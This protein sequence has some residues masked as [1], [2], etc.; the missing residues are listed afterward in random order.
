[1]SCPLLIDYG[2]WV[3]GQLL[4]SQFRCFV[5]SLIGIM[6]LKVEMLSINVGV[7]VIQS[8]FGDECKAIEMTSSMVVSKL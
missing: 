7:L 4:S 2:V 5:V 6:V 3:G 8:F 1:M